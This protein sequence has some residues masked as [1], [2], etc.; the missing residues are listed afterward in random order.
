MDLIKI[1]ETFPDQEA[2]IVYLERFSTKI[3]KF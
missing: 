2:C 3:V 1:M